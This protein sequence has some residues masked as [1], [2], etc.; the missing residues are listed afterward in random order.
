M[1]TSAPHFLLP[2]VAELLSLYV[3]SKSYCDP[4]WL[5][6]NLSFIFQRVVLQLKIVVSLFP[7]DPGLFSMYTPCLPE[8]ILT[9]VALGNV[10]KELAAEWGWSGCG[11][12]GIGSFGGSD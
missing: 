11:L 7:I 3:F 4:G 8:L 5:L 6:V 2:L 10:N 9:V 1:G 12:W